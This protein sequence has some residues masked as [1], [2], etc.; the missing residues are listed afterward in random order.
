M[1]QSMGPQRGGHDLAT[2][3]QHISARRGHQRGLTWFPFSC[4]HPLPLACVGLPLFPLYGLQ[5][6][7]MGP[8]CQGLKPCCYTN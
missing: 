6:K 1:L 8:E 2:E 5:V 4:S 3:Q 7:S